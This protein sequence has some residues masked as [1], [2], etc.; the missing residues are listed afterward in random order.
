MVMAN[1]RKDPNGLHGYFAPV[2][3]IVVLMLG[4]WVLSEWNALPGLLNSA[5]ATIK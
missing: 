4:Y 5:I 2:I 1:T 3:S